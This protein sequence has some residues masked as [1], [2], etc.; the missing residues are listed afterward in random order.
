MNIAF[1]DYK[2]SLDIDLSTLTFKESHEIGGICDWDDAPDLKVTASTIGSN[3]VK[4]L[5]K[6]LDRNIQKN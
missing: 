6:N 4:K 5:V 1:G 3:K 2:K